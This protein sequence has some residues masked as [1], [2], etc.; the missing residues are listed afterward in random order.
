MR[1]PSSE[2]ATYINKIP[3]KAMLCPWLYSIYFPLTIHKSITPMYFIADKRKRKIKVCLSTKENP[4]R[5]S[6]EGWEV[7]D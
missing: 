7:L 6:M 4:F 1:N 3:F 5:L 2:N